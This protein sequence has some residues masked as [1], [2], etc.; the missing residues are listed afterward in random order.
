[1]IKKLNIK[2]KS[3]GTVQ[4]TVFN[5]FELWRGKLKIVSIHA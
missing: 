3:H 2:T 5:G 4:N 1:M